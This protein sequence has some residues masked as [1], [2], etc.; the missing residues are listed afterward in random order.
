MNNPAAMFRRNS[1]ARQLFDL[2]PLNIS[3]IRALR[4]HRVRPTLTLMFYDVFDALLFD[5]AS[6]YFF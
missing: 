6:R 2:N 5:M 4:E 1:S 3:G